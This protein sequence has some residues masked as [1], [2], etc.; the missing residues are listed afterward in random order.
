MKKL[1]CLFA[2]LLFVGQISAAALPTKLNDPRSTVSAADEPTD[3]SSPSASSES[4]HIVWCAKVLANDTDTYRIK[5]AAGASAMVLLSGDN[6]TDLDLYVYNSSGS[7][8][9]SDTDNTDD[10]VCA[11][12]PS[13]NSFYTIKVV[14]RGGVYNVYT[15]GITGIYQ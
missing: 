4:G 7:L 6:D 2:G 14:N 3:L 9:D 13:A 1:L 12:K 5:F 8:V 15:I 11:W 10:C